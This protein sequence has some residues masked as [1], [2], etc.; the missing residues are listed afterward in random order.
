MCVVCD[1]DL[2]ECVVKTLVWMCKSLKKRY[3][4]LYKYVVSFYL[5]F[6]CEPELYQCVFLS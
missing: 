5:L 3:T 1:A 6:L 2:G 4:T